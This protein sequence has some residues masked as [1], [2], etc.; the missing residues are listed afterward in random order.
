PAP[1]AL[2]AAAAPVDVTVIY[3][4]C[5]RCGRSAAYR[6]TRRRHQPVWW[7]SW[8]ARDG[9]GVTPPGIAL[10][11]PGGARHRVAEGRPA[12]AMW[13]LA[14]RSKT[15]LGQRP[16]SGTPGCHSGCPGPAASSDEWEQYGHGQ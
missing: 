1:S 5:P 11:P 10:E 6:A 8:P 15:P 9:Y 14:K 7:G 16:A 2:P 13:S 4:K 12:V 3:P